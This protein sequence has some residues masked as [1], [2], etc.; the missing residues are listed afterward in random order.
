MKTKEQE[1]ALLGLNEMN[2]S[3]K[4]EIVG[5][6]LYPFPTKDDFIVCCWNIPPMEEIFPF[7]F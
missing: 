6:V 4:N 2:G 3:E 5:G 7:L 1:L